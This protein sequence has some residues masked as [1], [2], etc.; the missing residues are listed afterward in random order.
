MLHSDP[1]DWGGWGPMTSWSLP[2]LGG[3][4]RSH[5]RLGQ[6]ALAQQGAPRQA[7]LS[8]SGF[9]QM[10]VKPQLPRVLCPGGDESWP[11]GRVCGF[12]QA[13]MGIVYPLGSAA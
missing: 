7:V 3:A 5:G 10:S 1:E 13:P 2:H 8:C 6:D 4:E 11:E 9:E 12:L